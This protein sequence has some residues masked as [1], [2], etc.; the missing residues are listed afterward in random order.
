MTDLEEYIPTDDEYL[1]MKAAY[2]LGKQQPDITATEVLLRQDLHAHYMSGQ[3]YGKWLKEL[4]DET[5][6]RLRDERPP[7]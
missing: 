1:D 2:K 5:S 4:I 3:L 6:V 7:T